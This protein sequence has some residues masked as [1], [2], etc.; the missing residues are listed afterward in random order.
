MSEHFPVF[1]FFVVLHVLRILIFVAQLPPPGLLEKT[2]LGG[3]IEFR[4]ISDRRRV[5]DERL[6]QAV[7]V[8]ANIAQFRRVCSDKSENF[9]AGWNI[10]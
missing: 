9:V 6:Q 8:V 5:A 4:L 7:D 10:N 2:Q 1:K 3:V